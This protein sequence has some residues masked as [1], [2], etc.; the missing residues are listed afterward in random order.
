MCVRECV[1][2][3]ARQWAWMREGECIPG[4]FLICE[5]GMVTAALSPAEVTPS[6]ETLSTEA[7]GWV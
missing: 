6:F 5:T 3:C 7:L 2:A 1:C 4:P